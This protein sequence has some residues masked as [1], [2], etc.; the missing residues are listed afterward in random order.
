[1]ASN[2]LT[3]YDELTAHPRLAE[4]AAIAH[5]VIRA[6]AEEHRTE[7][8][9]AAAKSAEE[10]GLEAGS[11]K[12]S[13]GDA[14]L[15]LERGPE[16]DAERALACALWA[17][18]IAEHRPKS[19]EDEDELARDLLWLAAF[20]PFDATALL[21]RA[22]GDDANDLWTAVASVVKKIDAR[23]APNG[24]R[25]EALVGYAALALSSSSEAQRLAAQVA[26]EAVDPML[27]TLAAGRDA[28]ETT[29]F[30]A[31]IAPVP[32]GPIATTALALTG[33]LFVIHAIGL[34]ARYALALERPA[35][36][37]LRES[38][39]EVESKTILL[40]RTL[41][42]KKT[43]IPRGELVRA[44]REVRYPRAAFYTGLLSLAVGSYFGITMLVDGT[45]SASPS[46]LLAGLVVV[47]LG[48]AMDFVLR[49][50]APGAAGK[51]RVL[52][53]PKRGPSLCVY[54]ADVKT[55][56][57]ALAL[58]KKG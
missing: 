28:G 40:G 45:R 50:I 13:F 32:R 2:P 36:V 24:K 31:Q 26:K 15:V 9:S 48:I 12:T 41:Q 49:S 55:A 23:Q 44:A 58:M 11:T 51:C 6:M 21:D 46:L 18:A 42:E 3:A 56:D 1:M 20:T 5:A 29:H 30:S 34:V 7:P 14:V 16:D 17:H 25:A 19:A 57:R 33:L 47:A 10:A 53:V 52:F 37:R 39:V 22:L 43:V 54:A 4:L 38:E 8:A 27:K 35:E